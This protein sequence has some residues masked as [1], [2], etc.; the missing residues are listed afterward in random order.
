MK[1]KSFESKQG[2]CP[3]IAIFDFDGTLVEH[4]SL[5]P[6]LLAVAGRQRCYVACVK[7]LWARLTA[8]AGQDRRSLFKECLLQET[9]SGIP[10]DD[11]A[12]AAEAISDWPHWIETTKKALLAH[13]EQGHHIVIASGGLNVYLP[14]LLT[15]LPYNSL[16]CT[17]L[18]IKDGLATGRMSHGG[19][20]VRET[21]ASLIAA[22]MK[23]N[24]PFEDSIAYGNLPHDEPMMRLT[25][26]RVVV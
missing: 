23:E 15:D 3:T 17:E 4:D 8:L 13:H 19:N 22:Y 24:G 18:E 12:K 25:A 1:K 6:F 20:C 7:A 11:L 5:W 21:K 10:V 16:I 14:R 26:R 9:L 2:I